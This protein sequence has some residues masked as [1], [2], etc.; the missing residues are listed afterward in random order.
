MIWFIP[1]LYSFWQ[2]G[3]KLHGFKF[4]WLHAC[5]WQDRH[6]NMLNFLIARIRLLCS[7][8]REFNYKGGPTI[9]RQ[10][11]WFKTKKSELF[12]WTIYIGLH[13]DFDFFFAVY[14]L[15][16]KNIIVTVFF[17]KYVYEIKKYIENWS[18]NFFKSMLL[19]KISSFVVFFPIWVEIISKPFL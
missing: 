19:T 4:L 15:L 7:S 2:F 18:W 8:G 5:V 11:F 14:M 9:P 3:L 13:F 16:R 1:F 12:M 10:Q 17:D 6:R